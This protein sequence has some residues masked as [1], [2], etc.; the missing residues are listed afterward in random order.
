MAL[1]ELNPEGLVLLRLMVFA[2]WWGIILAEGPDDWE[3]WA[4]PLL[5]YTPAL[6]S[7]LRK[8]MKNLSQHSKNL[9]TTRIRSY[10]PILKEHIDISG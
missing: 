7:Q 4:L 3:W 6:A 2:T 5:D 8:S 1:W 9:L 10:D